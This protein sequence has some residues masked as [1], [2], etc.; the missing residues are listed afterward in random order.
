MFD[1]NVIKQS[2]ANFP[3][4]VSLEVSKNIFVFYNFCYLQPCEVHDC[5]HNAELKELY[6][7][8]F[9]LPLFSHLLSSGM[10]QIFCCRVCISCLL[11][12]IIN[13]RKFVSHG[14]VGYLV[15]ALSCLN[16]DIRAAACHCLSRFYLHLEGSRFREKDQV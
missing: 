1:K 3:I 9:L 8:R 16:H 15:V 7:P 14:C 6:D 11:G 12:N 4:N 5:F 2:I 10:V 13:C